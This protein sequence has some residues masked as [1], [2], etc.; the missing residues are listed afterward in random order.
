MYKLH[1]IKKY[2]LKRRIAWVALL[3]VMLCTAMV[4]VVISVMGGWLRMFQDSFHGITGDVVVEARSLAGF[5][6]YQEIID[7]AK[8]E[9]PGVETAVPVIST[10]GMV[11]I[12]NIQQPVQ[13]LGFTNEIGTVIDWPTS[14]HSQYETR[15][16]KPKTPEPDFS[17]LPNVDYAQLAGRA[18]D[19]GKRPGMIVSA[20]LIGIHGGKDA[21]TQER[22][23]E[24]RD[25]MRNAR[26]SLMV[27]P[28]KPGQGLTDIAPVQQGF[29]IVDDSRTR[30][31][32]VD[33][34]TVYVPFDVIQRD[35]HMEAFD[36][37]PARASEIRVKAKPGADLVAVRDAV[38]QV[39]DAVYAEHPAE[40]T[41]YYPVRVMTWEESQAKFID[42]VKHEVVLTT[43]LFGIISMVAVL[44]IFCI[45]YMIVVEKTKD[46]GI[47]K[48]VGATGQGIM[49]LFLGYG[50]AIGVV[51]AGLGFLF[52]YL[53][54]RYINELH[55]W[56]GR[57]MGIKIWDPETYQFETIPNK[58][59][60]T[61]VFWILVVAVLSALLGALVPAIRAARMN[62]VE[63][64]RYE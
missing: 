31:W 44:L 16:D 22:N 30:L 64:L 35:L 17:L 19:H 43:M 36:N 26:V 18:P 42:A 57:A 61:T 1:L 24:T 13:V 62:P 41:A 58:M 11:N 60:P 7:R 34:N 3:A 29:W 28:M 37:E 12:N 6:Y 51:G 21:A 25:I 5:P 49:S 59:N 10:G 2:L 48:S 38:R 53:V 14:L 63:A 40:D 45:F 23:E 9:V 50:L 56:M 20:A 8:K 52:A 55:A 47:I 32:Q 39:V 54:V 46:I 4:L 27:V 33:Y 15:A